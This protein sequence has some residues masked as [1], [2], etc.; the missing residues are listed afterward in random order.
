MPLHEVLA[1]ISPAEGVRITRV[2]LVLGPSEHFA[3]DVARQHFLMNAQGTPAENA[4]LDIE[5]LPV[6]YR[7]SS[8]LHTFSSAESSQTVVCPVCGSISLEIGH[9]RAF[10]IREIEVDE[11]APQSSST[12]L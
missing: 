4:A 12:S 7:C 3:E 1:R 2:V 6:I 8:C 9:A 11:G 5:R 10:Y